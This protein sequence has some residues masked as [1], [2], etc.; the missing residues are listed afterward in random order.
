[1]ASRKGPQEEGASGEILG[2]SR[3][4]VLSRERVVLVSH[5]LLLAAGVD[6]PS[7]T[8]GNNG[9]SLC[10]GAATAGSSNLSGISLPRS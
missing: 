1:M 9:N 2:E 8:T 3:P 4:G 10:V 6:A 7:D 5:L